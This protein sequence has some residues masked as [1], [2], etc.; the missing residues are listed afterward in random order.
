MSETLTETLTLRLDAL[1]DLY[2]AI[3]NRAVEAGDLALADEL[4]T[5]YDADSL[6][7]TRQHEGLAA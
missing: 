6:R 7:L 4:A 1:H 5:A 2:V 3:V